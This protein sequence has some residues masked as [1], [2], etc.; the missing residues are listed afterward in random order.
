MLEE[1]ARALAGEEKRQQILQ[2]A[3]AWETELDKLDVAERLYRTV[4]PT[5]PSIS[6]LCAAS[7]AC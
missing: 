7:I 2:L 5:I 1:R 3:E 4:L 6:T